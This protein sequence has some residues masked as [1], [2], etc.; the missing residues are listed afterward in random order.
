[1]PCEI[2]LGGG[3]A[4]NPA[5]RALLENE[6][7]RCPGRFSLHTHEEFG[8]RSDAKEAIAFALL[9]YATLHGIPNNVPAAT[10]ASHPC[11]LG[12]IVPGRM[13]VGICR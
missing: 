7:K 4:F 6:L 10:G 12:K 1:M 8:I 13:M 9:A 3:G 11:A 2:V 5:L